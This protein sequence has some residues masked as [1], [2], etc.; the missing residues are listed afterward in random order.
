MSVEARARGRAEILEAAAPAIARHGYHGMSMR[1]LARSSGRGLASLYTHFRAKEDILFE[2]QRQTF[3][4]LIASAEKAAAAELLPAARAYAFTLNHLR[5]FDHHPDVMRVLVREAGAL[6]R[7]QRATVR[8]LKERYFNLGRQLVVDLVP[9]HGA[10][11]GSSRRSYPDHAELDRLTY[12][13]FGML[14]WVHGWYEPNRHGAPEALA[15]TIFRLLISGVARY[16]EDG[17][18]S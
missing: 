11:A 13:Y 10:R 18:E 4:A 1:D 7:A 2:L 5:F 6:P 15:R 17:G 8:A 12:T 3:E 9:K 14:N 16:G